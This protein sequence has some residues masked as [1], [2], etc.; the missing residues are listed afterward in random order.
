MSL[1]KI[2]N[3]GLWMSLALAS[4]ACSNADGDSDPW[5]GGADEADE[6]VDQG[7]GEGADSAS[8]GG[9]DDDD[10]PPVPPPEG[11]N[12]WLG[13]QPTHSRFV[14]LTHAQWEASVE[15]LL[16][17]PGPSGLSSSLAEDAPSGFF[18]NNERSLEVG[19][20]LW[21]D[22]Q[23]IVEQLGQDAADDPSSLAA[24]TGGTRDATTFIRAFGKRA[25]RRP[26]TE[27]EVELYE[28]LFDT[29]AEAIGSG[30]A[31]ADG[32]QLVIEGMLQSPYFLYRTELGRKGSQLSGYEMAAKLS[33]LL[34]GTT[35]DDDLLDAAEQGEL[36]TAA[37]V[38]DWAETLLDEEN[39]ERVFGTFHGQLFGLNRYASI[40]KSPEV[41]P[42]FNATM[43]PSLEEADALFF[44]YVFSND[45]GLEDLLLSTV[46]FVNDAIAFIYGQ[47]ASGQA[48]RQVDLGPQRPGILTRAGFLA[49]H[50]SLR[51]SD[52]I[53][54]GADTIHRL[55]CMELQPPPGVIDM[56]PDFEPGQ[57]NRERVNAHTGPGTCGE[58]CHGTLINPLGFAFENFDSLG[59]LRETDNGKPVDT[60][61][62]F[63]FP[64]GLKAFQDA[65]ELLELMVA[66]P[67]THACYAAH[68]AEFVLG[69]DL[70]EDDRAIANALM[71]VSLKEQ[72]SLKQLIL[73]A[74]ESPAFMT[75]VG[76]AP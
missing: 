29:G 47:Q 58:T 32:V 66:N 70:N 16:A 10:M 35:P 63:A 33:L 30:D 39:A 41:F 44:D 14:R 56:L 43:N 23:R 51:D 48:F 11:V 31:F 54:R 4:W 6:G 72:G 2:R 46:G 7:S 37:G 34:R 57:T 1:L 62:E 28:S 38:L 15:S 71:D 52:P 40:D 19:P 55:L 9:D 36:D 64:D 8:E 61:G 17:I 12:L 69:R 60:T 20:V 42:R 27:D 68:V 75:H 65:R 5:T 76:G 26:L 45:L 13:G 53:H 3:A 74:I 67:Q 22:Y 49:L 24:V 18:S 25:F 59:Q 50:G 73:T 21:G